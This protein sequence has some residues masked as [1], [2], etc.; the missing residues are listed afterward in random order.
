MDITSL[1]SS[2]SNIFLKGVHSEISNERDNGGPDCADYMSL[3][4]K[5]GCTAV[6]V[7]MNISSYID[8]YIFCDL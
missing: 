3:E 5:L 4:F 1:K 6:M 2:I 8:Y 7:R